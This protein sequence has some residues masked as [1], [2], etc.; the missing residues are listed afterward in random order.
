MRHDTPEYSLIAAALTGNPW[1]PG[2]DWNWDQTVAIAAR[3]EVLP[4]LHAKLSCPP[5]VS[6][7]FEAIHEL[8]A[9]RNRRLIREVEALA[10]LLNQAGTEPVLLKGAAYLTTDVYRDPADRFLLDIDLLVGPR[11]SEQAFEVIRCAGYESDVSC[12]VA[13]VLHHHPALTQ[14]YRVPVEIHH[15]LAHGAGGAILTADEIIASSTPFRFGAATVRIPSPEHL[16][17]HLIIHSQMQHG[18]GDRIWPTLRAMHDLILLG[19]RFPIDWDA[20]RARFAARG[21]SAI[22]NLHLLQVERAMGVPPPFA[23]AGGGVR[24]WYRQALWRETRLRYVDPF[25]ISSR[26]VWP[27]IRLSWRLL[28]FPVG[29]KYVLSTP[30]RRSFYKRLLGL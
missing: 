16:M 30:F 13:L 22:L 3:E 9:E 21:K 4:T 19:R 28:K 24:W 12:P 27:R 26:T 25:Y 11:Q 10:L 15:S 7:F 29:R 1:L 18:S 14:P 20:V 6:D 2:P 5:E 23:I 17:T 8:N